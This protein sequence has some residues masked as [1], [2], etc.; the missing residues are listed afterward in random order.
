MIDDA[1]VMVCDGEAM[2]GVM[3][4]DHWVVVVI[5]VGVRKDYA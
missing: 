3:C 2:V 1:C 4:L 5:S